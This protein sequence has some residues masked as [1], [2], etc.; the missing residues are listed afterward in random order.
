M[1]NSFQLKIIT[2]DKI[3]LNETAVYCAVNTG[4]GKIAFKARHEPFVSTLQKNSKIEYTLENDEQSYIEIS[5][6]LFSFRDN[7]C[8]I[9][10]Y[11][12]K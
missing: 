6:G 3:L 2:F 5:N 9:L 1:K 4:K 7:K 8:T 11:Q 10:T 12:E